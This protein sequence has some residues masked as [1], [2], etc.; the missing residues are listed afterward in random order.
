MARSGERCPCGGRLK[1][2]HSRT[3]G[4]CRVRYL[5]C[6]SCE[7][8]GREVVSV[9]DLGRSILPVRT[10]AGNATESAPIA[11]R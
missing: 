2:Y 5:R 9:D 6:T 11:P 7:V 1:V 3:A 8:T 10:T 4:L